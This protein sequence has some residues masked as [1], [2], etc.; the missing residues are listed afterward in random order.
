MVSRTSNGTI[1]QPVRLQDGLGNQ[2]FQYAFG[3]QLAKLHGTELVF[4]VSW[5]E[6]AMPQRRIALRD[7]SPQAEFRSGS[8]FQHYWIRP[9]TAGKIWWRI[10]QNL[11]PRRWRWFVQQNPAAFP[12]QA[13]MFDPQFLQVRPGTYVSGW[14]ISPRYF[15]GIEADLRRELTL[16]VPLTERARQFRNMIQDGESVAIH[17]RR[18]D[19]LNHPEIGVLD[20]AYY[21]RA[22]DVIRS[23]VSQPRFY[24]FSDTPAEAMS[25]LKGPM[26]NDEV[27][28]V[29][30]EPGVSPAIDLTL[31]S[32]CRH[33]INA[34]S[35]F[36]W[37]GAWLSPHAQK[38][39][40]V[41]NHWYAG[42][43]VEVKD[44]YLQDWIRVAN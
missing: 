40:I 5:F 30:L 41:P 23:R 7:F 4:D 15:S 25:L 1:I 35:T 44:V 2:L 21:R 6:N 27:K 39:V 42:A 11:V 18:G 12:R 33:F 36:S 24:L 20:S 37:W 32:N 26:S 9:T 10:E 31:I 28:L 14:W 8:E 22:L 19:Y 34:N 3:R 17:I 43:R 38:T 16:G 13:Q 29:Q